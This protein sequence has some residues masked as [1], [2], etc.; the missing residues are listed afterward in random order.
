VHLLQLALLL[1]RKMVAQ[2][3]QVQHHWALLLK[4]QMVDLDLRQMTWQQ[5]AELQR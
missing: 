4:R 2:W 1:E 3:M 5:L